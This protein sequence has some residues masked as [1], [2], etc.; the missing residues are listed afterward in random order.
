MSITC[1][2][3]PLDPKLLA[4]C[5]LNQF[6][7]FADLELQPLFLQLS[8]FSIRSQITQADDSI[9]CHSVSCN[10]LFICY[11]AVRISNSIKIILN[12]AF[13]P[14]GRFTPFGHN[15]YSARLYLRSKPEFPMRCAIIL[16]LY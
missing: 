10:M 14:S 7:A 2:S 12:E 3:K 5:V 13:V 11:T 6:I 15:F 16:R 4:V 1:L 8:L 9:L